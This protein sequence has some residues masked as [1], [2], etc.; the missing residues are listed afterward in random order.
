MKPNLAIRLS[1]LL[2]LGALTAYVLA[3][4]VPPVA[5]EKKPATKLDEAVAL[6][7]K[8]SPQQ[9]KEL[10]A[11]VEASDPEYEAAQRYHALCLY[12]LKDY[13]GF[14]NAVASFEINAPVV[15]PEVQ[16]DL[17]F[18]QIDVL[19][20]FRKFFDEIF[21]KI[22]T[23]RAEHPVSERLGAVTEYQLAAL[24]ERGIK[25]ACEAE[26]QF[27]DT[28]LFNALWAE[29]KAN[30]E[31]F[32]SLASSFPGTNYSILPKRVFQEDLWGARLALGDDAGVF[33]EIPVKDAA[34]R[35]KASLLRVRQHYR[36][37]K[38]T[39]IDKNIQLMSDFL[40]DFPESSACKRV[41]Y[42][43]ANVNFLGGEQLWKEADAAEKAGDTKTAGKKR[44]AAGKY[45][46]SA[47]SLQSEVVADKAAGIETF[48][49][50]DLRE[51]LLRSYYWEQDYAGIKAQTASLL[52]GSKPGETEW[53]L[54]KVY[55]GIVSSR[56]VPPKLSEAAATFD[57]VLAF[58]FKN[59]HRNDHLVILAA[60]WRISVARRSGDPEKAA[61]IVRWV[62][63][64]DCSQNLK[65]D[66]LKEYGV[67]ADQP[68]N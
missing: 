33:G 61:A 42:D 9:A 14:T 13:S 3:Q 40:K 17:A 25:K 44:A 51:D 30:F 55:D 36:I 10:L 59:N 2:A 32:V 56:A 52:A 45:L 19:F 53:L 68:K 23:F 37:H 29:S 26:K 16:E 5:T 50:L 35:E 47:R 27:Q 20:R 7:I 48:D 34:T 65:T 46:Q 1:V 67:V 41:E 63:A 28:N 22:Q 60:R 54:G 66:F 58:G 24:Y 43:L 12:E 4:P 62:Q 8:D 57:E 18:K 39:H 15:P 21:P 64:S 31:E 49:V 11:T 38:D 6:L